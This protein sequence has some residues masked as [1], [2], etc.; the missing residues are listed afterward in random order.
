MKDETKSIPTAEFVELES[1]T[2]SFTKEENKG[3]C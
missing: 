1:E 3:E 2:H